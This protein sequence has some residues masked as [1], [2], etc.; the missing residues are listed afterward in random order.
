MDVQEDLRLAVQVPESGS[1]SLRQWDDAK[2]AYC[3]KT[4]VKSED[5]DV[6]NVIDV[7]N[8]CQQKVEIAVY[9]SVSDLVLGPFVAPLV[10]SNQ[11]KFTISPVLSQAM[12]P[13]P[14]GVSCEVNGKC[15]L[16]MVM[17]TK[18]R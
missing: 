17:P 9:F 5:I 3:C 8:R 14:L 13:E 1:P 2:D 10:T 4:V 18:A 16:S 6:V 12:S 11:P 15:H 7:E